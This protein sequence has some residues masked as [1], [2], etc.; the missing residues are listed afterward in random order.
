MP[1]AR[2]KI[3]LTSLEYRAEPF[4]AFGRLRAWATLVPTRFP[5]LGKIWLVTTY[6]AVDEVLRN[7][8]LFCRDPRNAGRRNF[9]M[10]Q[11][12]MPGLFRRLSQNMLAAD[13]PDHRR[14]RSLV[15]QAFQ[16]QSIDELRPRITQL[17]H[18]QL[19]LVAV[20]AAR[21]AGEVDLIEHLARPVPLNV[22]CEVLGLPAEDRG[23]FKKWFS[24]FANIKSV[25]GIPKVVPGLRKTTR[26]LSR[27]F[28]QVRRHP[29]AGLITALVEAEQAG[30]RLSDDEL[31]SMVLMLLLAG[32]E[33]TVHLLSNS[34]LTLLRLPDVRQELQSDWTRVEAAVEEMMRY[35]SPAQF[36]KP[37]FVTEDIVF[38]G[39]PLRCGEVVMPVLAAA[40]G[41]PARFENPQQFQINR[42]KNYHLGFGGGPHVCLG[43]K[44]ARAEAQIVLEQLF[45]RWPD[46]EPAFDRPDW[47]RRLGMRSLSSL[48]V[49]GLVLL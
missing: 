18:E 21:N 42:P 15:D 22:I 16:R 35:N 48:R 19:D 4:E 29:R 49:R 12:M 6:D 5:M 24:S 41:D 10:F 8:R 13:E 37:R 39:Q 9:P 2:P 11:L 23:R 7:D 14:L 44:L 20:G 40:N 3:D 47:S 1:A 38:Y 33:T 28:E 25:W 43:M 27:Q 26:Y 45:T 36:A 34:I 17:V 30:D 46:L 31:Q 32:H